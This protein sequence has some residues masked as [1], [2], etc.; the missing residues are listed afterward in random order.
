MSDTS[1]RCKNGHLIPSGDVYCPTCNPGSLSET[2]SKPAP[3]GANSQRAKATPDQMI[4]QGNSVVGLGCSLTAF[5]I[6][7]PIV[8]VILIVVI[9]VLKAVVGG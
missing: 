6:L 4:S 2:W 7:L 1:R 5:V 3:A 8:A 9:G